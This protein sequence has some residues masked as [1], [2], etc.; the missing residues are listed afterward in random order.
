MIKR[1][2]SRRESISDSLLNKKLEKAKSYDRIAG[3]FSS[4]IFEI[5]GEALDNIEGK[6][7]IVCNSDLLPEDVE[8]AKKAQRAI[9]KEWCQNEPEKMDNKSLR[10]RKLYKYLVSDKLEIR[11]LPNKKFGLVHG[12]AGII[13]LKNGEQTSFLGSVNESKSGWNINYELVWEDDSKEA[14]EW[15]QEEFNALWNS[16]AAI[17]LPDFIIKDIKRIANREIIDEVDDFNEEDNIPAAVNVESPIYR[18]NLGLWEHQKFFIEKVFEDHKKFGGARY[19]LADPVGLGKTLQLAVS[20][21]LMALYGDKP[22]LIIVPKTLMKQ[23]QDELNGMLNLPSA[24]WDGIN[25][26]DE[27]GIKYPNNGRQDIIKCPRKIGIISQGLV[28]AKSESVGYLMAKNYECIIVDEAHHARRKSIDQNNK[29]HSFQG[30]NLYDYLLKIAPK[31]KSLLLATAT[32]IQLHPVELWDL[33]NILSHGSDRILGT[34]SSLW[35]KKGFIGK[36]LELIKKS[37]GDLSPTEKWR[38]I[39]NPFPPSEEGSY[40]SFLRTSVGVNDEKVVFPKQYNELENH[41]R[42]LAGFLMNDYFELHNPYIRHVVRREREYLENKLNPKTGEPYLDKIEVEIIDEPP[43]KLTGYMKDAYDYAEKFCQLISNRV[44][45]GGFL[46][47]LLLKRIGSS[48]EAG[49]K[50]GLKLK[51]NWGENLDEISEEEDN[52]SDSNIKDLTLQEQ[53]MLNKYVNALLSNKAED[54]KFNKLINLLKR[55]KWIDEGVIIFSQY[56]DTVEWIARKLSEIFT[57]Q[58]IGIYA[59]SGKAGYFINENFYKKTKD[60]IKEMVMDYNLKILLGTDAASEGLNLQALRRL[61]NIDL[62]WNPTR[63]EQRKGRI[64]RGGQRFDKIYL[65]NMKYKN[66]VEDR[67]HELLSERLKNITAIFGQLPDV[68]EDAWINVALDQKEEAK[69]IIDKVPEKHPFEIKYNEDVE[70]SDWE[71]CTKI[72]SEES[73]LKEL[74]SPW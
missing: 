34:K 73:K 3:Y 25:W 18:K 29:F 65:Y 45:G 64:Q 22:V 31:T 71:N 54:P 55:D 47:T 43:L 7:R 40:Y 4:S 60:D 56:Y 17:P 14:V 42:T 72:L 24:I 53:E 23:W 36:G 74:R 67:V 37:G 26:I 58:K 46:K 35:R 19:V 21:Q 63:L 30:T 33:L 68:L 16:P 6:I 41:D 15:V 59:G 70:A 10:F 8:T 38:W 39:K 20:A 32:P 13:T 5:A 28:T 44:K 49:K 1:Y 66:S 9:R 51:N 61:V 50:T 11:V 12:K 2:S 57:D 69:K 48:I 27:N 52:I 62:P